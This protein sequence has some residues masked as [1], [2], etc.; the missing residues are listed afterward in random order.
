MVAMPDAPIFAAL[1]AGD[2]DRLAA[3][4]TGDP[5]AASAR[6]DVGLS[7]LM[8]A[9]YRFD[10]RSVELIQG[11]GQALDIFE[12]SALDVEARVAELLAFDPSQAFHLAPDGFSA[13]HLAAFFGAPR[14]ARL[15]TNAGARVNVLSR[16]DFGVMPL[17]SALAGRHVEV[18]RILVGAGADVNAPQQE[19][20]RPL[21]QAVEH[22][23]TE[24]VEMLMAVGADPSL[25]NDAG[26]TAA[27]FAGRLGHVALEARLRS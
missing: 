6:D 21:H 24:L 16:N 27:D 8:S 5:A 15:L 11:A 3:I 23:D 1:A 22:N 9:R 13:L 19:G 26:E 14:C 25:P 10:L 20:Y 18:C 2:H 12:A 7:V 17:H 4:L